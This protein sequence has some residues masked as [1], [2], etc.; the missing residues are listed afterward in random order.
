M[1][2]KQRDRQRDRR[3]AANA[4]RPGRD[5]ARRPVAVEF[6]R[7]VRAAQVL[8]ESRDAP[9]AHHRV[10]VSLLKNW[11][12]ENGKVRCYDLEERRSF[13]SRPE[14]ILHEKDYYRVEDAVIGGDRAAPPRLYELVLGQI[15]TAGAPALRRW[16]D[17]PESLTLSDFSAIASLLTAQYVRG[18]RNRDDYREAVASAYRDTADVDHPDPEH[19]WFARELREEHFRIGVSKTELNVRMFDNFR[20]WMD[21]LVSRQ[22]VL[23]ESKVFLPIGD[24]P[25]VL[26]GGPG[27]ERGRGVGVRSAGVVI[28]PVSPNRLLA[29]FRPDVARGL[30]FV[31]WQWPVEGR[32]SSDEGLEVAR[33]ICMAQDR[34]I[35]EHPTRNLASLLRI[36]AVPAVQ[37]LRADAPSIAAQHGAESAIHY[38]KETR[39]AHASVRGVDWPV[40]RWWR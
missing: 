26:V 7:V 23:F 4:T 30:G 14:G 38:Y 20:S 12:D 22:W 1:A 33:E 13:I 37:N 31:E 40:K 27:F 28:A 2:T 21:C 6:E 34:W 16:L 32:L 25:I 29:M 10:P 35:V 11:S 19:A 15:E 5:S 9:R 18:E 39:W 8:S 24:E 3:R 36:P 17:S